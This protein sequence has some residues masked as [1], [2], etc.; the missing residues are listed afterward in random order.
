MK[1]NKYRIP[2]SKP[3]LV[4][5]D[6]NEIKKAFDSSWIS[7][8]SPW[9]E[10]FEE[11]FARKISKTKYAASVNSGTS[12]LFLALKSLG[13]GEG[14]EVILPSL[15]MIAT[16]NA[17]TLTGA[18]SVLVDC[19]SFEDFNW[20]IEEVSKKITKKTK[21]LMPVHLYGYSADMEK[22]LKLAKEKKIYVVED[23]AE[24]M[25]AT[26]KR[27]ALGSFGD[28]SCYSL[29]SNKIITTANGGMVA[30]NNKKLYELVKKI[31]F[32]DFN[33][34]SH[35]TH[36]I[37]GYNM[38]LS[39]LQA[40]LGLSQTKRFEKMLARRREIF[41]EY[42]KYLKNQDKYFIPEPIKHQNPNY[43]FPAIIF[44]SSKVKENVRLHLLRKGIETRVFFRPLHTQP[45]YRKLFMGEKYEKSEY[46]YEHGLLLPSF[47]EL[48]NSQ[49]KEIS[50]LINS[51]I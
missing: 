37:I 22:L 47:Y 19:K 2:V 28:I 17:V 7:S 21:V 30:T 1:Y 9:V 31:S 44:K 39:G 15:T 34:D 24:S 18:K 29:Y 8:K 5:E 10:K 41:N 13:I 16:I 51:V 49:I 32:F 4:N 36:S 23:A 33:E 3:N 6:F 25:G 35:F 45:V 50:K 42:K 11:I 40:S 12:A 14:D 27:K 20:D 38:V 26:Y 43:W 46:F 48:K